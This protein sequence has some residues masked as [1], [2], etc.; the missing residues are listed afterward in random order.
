VDGRVRQE[1][2]GHLVDPVGRVVGRFR[3]Q[4]DLEAVGCAEVLQFE[5]EAF[6]RTLSRLGLG[7]QHAAFQSHRHGGSVGCHYLNSRIRVQKLL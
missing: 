1:P 3:V 7:V 6:Q 5:A 4:I 2:F